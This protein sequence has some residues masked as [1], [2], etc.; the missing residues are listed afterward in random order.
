MISEI[1]SD[2]LNVMLDHESIEPYFVVQENPAIEFSLKK[3]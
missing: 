3:T 1:K 2:A